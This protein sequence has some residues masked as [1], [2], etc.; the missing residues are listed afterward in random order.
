VPKQRGRTPATQHVAAIDAVR[1][2][3]HRRNESHHLAARIRRPGAL[4][5]IDSGVHDRLQPQP[6][7]EQPRQHNPGVR[8]GPLV[9]ETNTQA[10]ASAGG[11]GILHHV[12][13]LLTQ[14]AV[15]LINR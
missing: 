15:A 7:R 11:L 13:D 1:A 9:I 6:L 10:I 12:D 8:N 14:A 3:H 5:K 2:Q 4:A